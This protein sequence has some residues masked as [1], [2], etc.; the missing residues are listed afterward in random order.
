M[1]KSQTT[2]F[3]RQL[4]INLLLSSQST[5]PL[6]GGEVSS[7]RNRASIEDIFIK[8]SKLQTVSMGLVFF[9]SKGLILDNANDIDDPN[10]IKLVKWGVEIAMDTLRGGLD[11]VPDL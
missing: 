11:I 9:F 3:L 6:V 4:L 8:A 10:I 7:S 1:L 2:F 5:S